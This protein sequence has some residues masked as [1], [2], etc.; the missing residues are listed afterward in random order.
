MKVDLRF[1]SELNSEFNQLFN[2][3]ALASRA[4][5][6]D[7]I[8]SISKNFLG[9]IDWWVESP[10]SR[11]TYASSLFHYYC[12]AK[13]ILEIIQDKNCVIDEIEVDSKEL[14]QIIEKILRK[15]NFE[16]ITVSYHPPFILRLKRVL[17][18]YFYYYRKLH[19]Y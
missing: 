7:F 8:T 5:F 11:N 13:F 14:K 18:K 17:K 6:N 19:Q 16:K 12:S 2:E 3:V 4:E 10:A 15:F 1:H 9:N